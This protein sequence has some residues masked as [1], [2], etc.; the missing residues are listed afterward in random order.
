MKFKDDLHLEQSTWLFDSINSAVDPATDQIALWAANRGVPILFMKPYKF[1]R[2]I[3]VVS[4]DL[5]GH[6]PWILA[7]NGDTFIFNQFYVTNFNNLNHSEDYTNKASSFSDDIGGG[8]EY[9]RDSAGNFGWS[10]ATSMWRRGRSGNNFW[11]FLYFTRF[12]MPTASYDGTTG[13]TGF[14]FRAGLGANIATSATWQSDDPAIQRIC[15]ER[16]HTGSGTKDTNFMLATRD[17]STTTRT[18]TTLAFS[19][20]SNYEIWLWSPP[21]SDTVYYFIENLTSST[22]RQGLVTATLP[23]TSTDLLPGIICHNVNAVDRR[24]QVQK[25]LCTQVGI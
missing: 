21:G 2:P 5:W 13:T 20:Q 25:I 1:K 23:Q 9:Y 7:P 19:A 18:D 16:L 12:R 17:G 8:A 24:L 14:R 22:S 3:P 15:I 10:A 4:F 6:E 11:G